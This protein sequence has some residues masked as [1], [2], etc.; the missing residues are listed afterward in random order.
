MF[1]IITP[2]TNRSALAPLNAITIYYGSK[3]DI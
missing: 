3:V 1:D 2:K